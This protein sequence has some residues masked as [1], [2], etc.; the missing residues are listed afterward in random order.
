MSNHMEE[1]RGCIRVLF[2]HTLGVK[3]LRMMNDNEPQ[4]H[5][6]CY[7]SLQCSKGSVWYDD[8]VQKLKI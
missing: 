4:G 8:I 2:W 1:A 6:V 3:Q 7:T 5:S